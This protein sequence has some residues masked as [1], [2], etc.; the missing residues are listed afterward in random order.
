M[1]IK[2]HLD[3]TARIPRRRTTVCRSIGI[4]LAAITCC[5]SSG[6]LCRANEPPNGP[7]A[8]LVS[9]P[10]KL[11]GIGHWQLARKSPRGPIAAIAWNTDG[12]EIAYS[13]HTYVRICDAQTLETKK[14]LAGHSGPVTGIDWNRRTHRIASSSCDGTVRIWS[15]AGLPEKVLEPNA[16]ELKSVAWTNDGAHLAASSSRGA[17]CIWGADGR[18]TVLEMSQ[19]PIECLAWS[20]DGAGLVT[21]D[22]DGHVKLWTAGGKLVRD[23]DGP[24]SRVIAVA[25]SPDGKHFATT[26][27]GDHEPI[28][29]R[30]HTE[31]RIY[32]ADGSTVATITAEA[33]SSGLC[34]SPDGKRL[35]ISDIER[36]VRVCDLR[37][38]EVARIPVT[39]S[40]TSHPNGIAW[41]PK[42]EKL[43]IGSIGLV[44]VLDL[45]DKSTHTSPPGPPVNQSYRPLPLALPSPDLEKWL[46]RWP[47]ADSYEVWSAAAGKREAAL[48]EPFEKIAHPEWSPSGDAVA[49]AEQ[50]NRLRLW[51]VGAASS[52][53]V[54][55]SE[56][57]LE[58]IAW[59]RDGKTLAALDQSGNL[60]AATADGKILLQRK[61]DPPLIIPE[62]QMRDPISRVVFSSD[63]KSVAVVERGAVQM[64]P[65][66]GGAARSFPLEKTNPWGWGAN[67]WWS[68]DGLRMTT[69]RKQGS[70]TCQI[71]SW[72]LQTGGRTLLDKFGDEVSATDCSPDGKLVAL[73]YDTGF[74]QVRRLDD[75][76]AGPLESLPAVHL[77]TLR[78]IAFSP[79]GRRFATG[80]WEGWI[81]IW[82]GEGK[83]QQTLY[84]NVWPV[85][86]LRFSADGQ[87]LVSVARD[88]TTLLWSLQT[89]RP[90]LRFEK[91]G[92]EELTLLTADG[93]IFGPSTQQLDQEFCAL[94]EK[95][96]GAT[97]AV[98]YADF[99]QRIAA[100]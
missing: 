31:A 97:E 67:F 88:Q 98:G 14:F 96:S 52:R 10:R 48:P 4:A 57:P 84:G 42:G 8:G 77:A 53:V 35:A 78:S 91:A 11:P 30:E 90:Q 95:P 22:D 29:E 9:A 50:S 2:H 80:G 32:A 58:I 46:V 15:A 38:V 16:G 28:S 12:T 6:G 92:D 55:E 83:L 86:M 47:N 71:L 64:V 44:T 43:A 23:C 56:S 100:H 79:D 19:A 62:N 74:W 25:W 93:R 94:L 51:A 68:R 41:A 76:A 59:S 85:H 60:K 33:N 17:V 45:S 65:L 63:G 5:T 3:P 82:S 89:G 66:D 1:L 34:F 49:Y 37:G 69:L 70:S 26:A 61:L 7:L 27:Y 39:V 20:P 21:G 75:P 36:N 87:R 40:R 18:L 72:N 81:K 73:G 13:D 24:L 54:L 99:L